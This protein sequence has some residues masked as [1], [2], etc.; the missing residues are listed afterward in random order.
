[1]QELLAY[2]G[3]DFESIYGLSFEVSELLVSLFVYLHIG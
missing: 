3:D 1:M 2:E